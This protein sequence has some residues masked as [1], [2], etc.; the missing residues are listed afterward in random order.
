MLELEYEELFT[1]Q[2]SNKFKINLDPSKISS[3]FADWY[4]SSHQELYALFQNRT[5]FVVRIPASETG[6]QIRQ[7][8]S[9][10]A[11]GREFKSVKDIN[12]WIE[13]Q[14]MIF[15]EYE[16]VKLENDTLRFQKDYKIKY[17]DFNINVRKGQKLSQFFAKLVGGIHKDGEPGLQN[18]IE[19]LSSN[20]DTVII[21]AESLFLDYYA[22]FGFEPV[23]YLEM[24]QWGCN[25]SCTDLEYFIKHGEQMTNDYKKAVFTYMQRCTFVATLFRDKKDAIERN[26]TAIARQVVFYDVKSQNY[27]GMRAYGN[28]MHLKT[29]L[30]RVI[31][32]TVSKMGNVQY[33]NIP[34]A[35]LRNRD[36]IGSLSEVRKDIMCPQ[37]WCGYL[38][39]FA[40]HNY[41]GHTLFQKLE[42]E[43]KQLSLFESNPLEYSEIVSDLRIEYTKEHGFMAEKMI[44]R[45]GIEIGVGNLVFP[46]TPYDENIFLTNMFKISYF[47]ECALKEVPE[48]KIII[49]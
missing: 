24:G 42:Q 6:K 26:R 36:F 7:Y 33:K 15:K 19:Y 3:E 20:I 12:K 39:T 9:K 5:S 47:R 16:Y 10:L 25:V 2:F 32:D 4:V 11:K 13:S 43:T 38:D 29:I 17:E 49:K 22:R 41:E 28:S 8:L 44:E 46:Y 45:L 18:Y 48:Q 34:Y 21:K 31:G 30:S 1:K 23:D 35:N 27:M 14:I 40:Y 37:S